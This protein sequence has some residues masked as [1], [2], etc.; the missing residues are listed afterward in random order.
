MS[1]NPFGN[2][3]IASE[4]EAWYQLTE[5]RQFDRQE[6]AL[7]KMLLTRF[8][9]AHTL[10]E[11]GCG[12]GHFTRWFGELGLHATGIDLSSPMLTQ[13]A[14]LSS[15]NYLQGN[16]LTLPFSSRSFDLA[17]MITTLEFLP[18]P[19]QALT[20][21]LRVARRGIILGVL[22][23]KSSLGKQYRHTGGPIWEAANFF[24]PD[25]LKRLIR[26]V[27]GEQAII[28]WCTTLWPLWA[29]ALPL[30]WGGLIGMA[31]QI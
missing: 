6:K 16:A 23:A 29:G 31:V 22:N 4:Y 1:F 10:L 13:A 15:Q 14:S 21:M 18:E 25:E 27:V 5:N 9:N 17:T 24:T 19:V 20:E 11:V 7:L 28:T 3:K 12:T 30:P 8:P 26:E 2:P